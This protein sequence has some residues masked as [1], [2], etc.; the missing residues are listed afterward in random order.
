M[1][2][3]M[4]NTATELNEADARLAKMDEDIL[5]ESIDI[6]AI[7]DQLAFRGDADPVWR[8]RAEKAMRCQQAF[9]KSLL[10]KLDLMNHEVKSLRIKLRNEERIARFISTAKIVLTKEKFQE[11]CVLANS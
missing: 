4:T 5:K 10:R 8:H 7:Q 11:I 6:A 1:E 9:K 2:Y 3:V